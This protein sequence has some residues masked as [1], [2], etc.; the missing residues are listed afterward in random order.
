MEI[1]CK[2]DRLVNVDELKAHP[3]NRN[4]HSKE[5]VTRLSKLLR[6]QGIRAPIVVSNLSG[7]IVKGH[8][9]LSAIMNNQ[10]K[11][12]PVVFQDFTDEAQEYAFVQSDNAIASWS[13]LDLSGINMD[14]GTFGPEFD[15]EHLGIK[16][17]KIEVADHIPPVDPDDVPETPMKPKTKL[18]DLWTL[19]KHRL[20]CGDSTSVDA[21]ERLMG[22]E[23]ADMVFTD[24]PYGINE[25]TDRAYAAR[26]RIS[27]CNSFHK[28]IGDDS[29]NTAV[30][31]FSL[32]DSQSSIVC[33]WGG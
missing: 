18:G 26:S 21:V 12:A 11:Q 27:K 23:K 13:E 4:S 28:I 17:F 1:K 33:Y 10:A 22:G 14:I 5:Q 20:L 9:T 25:E 29:I 6:Y 30:A 31:A 24:P 19:G 2:Y 32:A 16:D 7:C 3:K 8:G 15:L